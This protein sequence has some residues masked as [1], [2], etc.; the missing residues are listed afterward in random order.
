MMKEFFILKKIAE[1]PFGLALLPKI[2]MFPG[3]LS[4]ISLASVHYMNSVMQITHADTCCV[5]YI[6]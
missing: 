5:L 1:H 3:S 2:K 6:F 4:W